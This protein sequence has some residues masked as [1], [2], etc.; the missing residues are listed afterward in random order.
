MKFMS[1]ILFVILGLFTATS[2]FAYLETSHTIASTDQINLHLKHFQTQKPNQINRKHLILFIQGQSDA[3]SVARHFLIDALESLNLDVVSY[4]VRGQGLSDGPRAHIDDFFDHLDDLSNVIHFVQ[5]KLKYQHIHFV[6]H[7]TGGLIASLFASLQKQ[8]LSEQ[9]TLTMVA[10]YFALSG[11]QFQSMGIDLLTYALSLTPVKYWQAPKPG[12]KG[13]YLKEDGSMN[14]FTSDPEMFASH[15]HHPDKCGR[16]TFGWVQASLEAHRIIGEEAEQMT[17]PILMFTATNDQVVSTEE[18]KKF[19]AKWESTSK[20]NQYI[21]FG[22]PHQHGLIYEQRETR[23]K[24]LNS[25]GGFIDQVTQT[26]QVARHHTDPD[27]LISMSS[28]ALASLESEKPIEVK[29]IT[30]KL[31]RKKSLNQ[32]AIYPAILMFFP[33]LTMLYFRRKRSQVK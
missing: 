5:N 22:A 18:A 16:P 25:I 4:D 17:L 13:Q 1:V 23:N 21:E 12:G 33:L 24:I 20:Y 11:S 30:H 2:S 28:R 8:M 15:K 7:S 14:N 26:S 3:T 31:I 9:S 27:L 10:P 19:Y 29:A 32:S 6:T